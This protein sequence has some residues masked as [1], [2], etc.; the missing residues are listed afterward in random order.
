MPTLLRL[1]ALEGQADPSRRRLDYR[2]LRTDE[3]AVV[4][5]FT[6]ARLLKCSHRS[7]DIP[8]TH[9][10]SDKPA[11]PLYFSS[12][13]AATVEVA[14]EAL[15]RQWLPL[16]RAIEDAREWL[17]RRSQLERLA[18]DWN[19]SGRDESFLLRGARLS[20]MD[21]AAGQ[22]SGTWTRSSADF[23]KLAGHLPSTNVPSIGGGG[24]RWSAWL[25]S[26]S[27]W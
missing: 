19:Q 12:P 18:A 6:E 25:W 7:S 4:D 26:S 8:S 10:E 20:A 2:T 1:A 21:R 13:P 17:E 23:S 11:E 27:Y 5:A 24:S 15:L 9:D 22:R 14:H 3:R 16:R